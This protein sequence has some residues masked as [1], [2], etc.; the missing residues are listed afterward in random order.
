MMEMGAG[1]KVRDAKGMDCV[2]GGDVG[3]KGT[4]KFP[5]YFVD[6]VGYSSR[7][8]EFVVDL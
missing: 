1:E 6:I 3:P 5:L 2:K 8:G 7:H 4:R